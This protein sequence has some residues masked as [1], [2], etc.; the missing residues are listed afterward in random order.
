MHRGLRENIY[1]W[2]DNVG[3]EID[4]IVDNGDKLLALE[5][6]SGKTVSSDF[7]KGLVYYTDLSQD[8]IVQQTVV[9]AGTRGQS[10]KPGSLLSWQS[11]GNFIPGE[12]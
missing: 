3:H 5:I 1:F 11:F 9:Y 10:R 12:I 7:F 4:C 8:M 2:R 6:K